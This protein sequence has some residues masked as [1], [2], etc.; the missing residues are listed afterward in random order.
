MCWRTR[1]AWRPRPCN[2]SSPAA[3]RWTPARR[4]PDRVRDRPGGR[5][6]I[7]RL[8]ERYRGAVLVLDDASMVSTDQMKR[9]MRIAEDL[10][11]A[12]LVLVGDRS[13]LRAVEAGQPFRLLQK[14]GMATAEMNE[15]LRQREPKLRGAANAVLE[16]EPGEAMELFGSSVHEV[17]WDELGQKAAEAWLSLDAETRARTLLVAPTHE[18]RA[19]INAAVRQALAEEGELRS[20]VLRIDRLVGLGI[21][22]AEMADVRNYREGDTVLFNQDMVNFRVPAFRVR[23][24]S[25]SVSPRRGL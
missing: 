25:P 21:T 22:R 10:E 8:K 6:A 4:L 20:R 13:Q 9:L 7:E 11:V 24:K 17:P 1:R 5:P 12:R 3:G 19:E 14:A 23:A 15:I 2:D 16:G 18:L